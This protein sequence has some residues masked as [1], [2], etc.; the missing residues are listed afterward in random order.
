KIAN[1]FG[2]LATDVTI[3]DIRYDEETD[4][5]QKLKRITEEQA[6]LFNLENEKKDLLLA[7]AK[8]EASL[9][10]TLLGSLKGSDEASGF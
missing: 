10:E 5:Y 2:V 4:S 1:R 7:K 8:L 3:S 6:H 9:E